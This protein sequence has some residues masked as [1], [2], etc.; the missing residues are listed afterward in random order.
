MSILVPVISR[1]STNLAFRSIC[2]RQM[3]AQGNCSVELP[4]PKGGRHL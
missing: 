4:L 3:T 1:G 2:V